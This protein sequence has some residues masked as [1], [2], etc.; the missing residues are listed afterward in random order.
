MARRVA[1]GAPTRKTAQRRQHMSMLDIAMALG[2]V[3]LVV[4]IILRK[5]GK[6]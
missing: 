3:V 1:R 6:G 5:K 4:L 2:V